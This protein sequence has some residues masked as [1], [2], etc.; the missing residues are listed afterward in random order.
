VR[1]EELIHALAADAPA[2]PPQ[3]LIPRLLVAVATALVVWLAL[4]W[5]DGYGLPARAAPH[6]WF[7]MKNVYSVALALAGLVAVTRLARPGGRM[8]WAPWL[9]LGAVAVLAI[10]AMRETMMAAP[11]QVAPLWLGSTWTVCGARIMLFSLPTFVASFWF[12][13]RMAPTQPMLAG[14]AAGFFA[15]AIGAATY[16]LYCQ[17]SAAAFV[18]AWYTLGIAI[19]AV[20][21]AALGRWLLRW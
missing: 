9:A 10:M 17:E 11:T 8:G 7:W 4:M 19:C 12:L 21:G 2:A 1:T 13:R 5:L 6:G 16:G 14:F 15:G 3:P 18:L 20:L